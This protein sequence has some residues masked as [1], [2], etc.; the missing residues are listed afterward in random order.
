MPKSF[1][2]FVD[3]IKAKVP[4]EGTKRLILGML[5]PIFRDIR[6]S[7][8]E[9]GAHALTKSPPLNEVLK[10]GGSTSKKTIEEIKEILKETDGPI[11]RQLAL[12]DE[13]LSRSFEAI[14]AQHSA[15]PSYERQ[16]FDVSRGSQRMHLS[17]RFVVVEL[18]RNHLE[19]SRSTFKTKPVLRIPITVYARRSPVRV[20][21]TPGA[22]AS[23]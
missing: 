23:I 5:N 3:A 21:S 16:A 10:E 20:S 19:I 1:K 15:A 17:T 4:N 9:N 6:D 2:M 7:T 14:A 8:D 18:I 13:L 12:F 11:Q 22:R